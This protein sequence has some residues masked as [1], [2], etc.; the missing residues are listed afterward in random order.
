ME[1]YWE[2]MEGFSIN[3]V[4]KAIMRALGENHFFPKPAE[5]KAYAMEQMEEDWRSDRQDRWPQIEY[6]PKEQMISRERAIEIFREISKRLEEAKPS[7]VLEGERA[8]EFEKSRVRA[9][10]VAKRC[11]S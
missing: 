3:L 10:Q 11:L 8:D 2:E 4:E 1:V 7:A 6:Q 5:L 9:K